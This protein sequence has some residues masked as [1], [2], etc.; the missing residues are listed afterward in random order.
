[1]ARIAS[2]LSFQMLAVAVG[3]RIY[4]L[5][6][7]AFDL[8]L[9]GLAQFIPMV[10]LTFLAG[11]VADRYDRRLVGGIC[12]VVEGIA[13]AV[14]AVGTVRGFLGRDGIYAAVAVIGA[15]RAFESPT[16]AAL[17]P[18]LLS[19][20]LV[21]R[22]S[23]WSASASQTAQI[24]GPALGGGLYILGPAIVFAV[25][26]GLFFTAAILLARIRK[27]P[28]PATRATITLRSF[29]AGLAFVWRD[30]P[31]LGT[32]SLDLFAVLFG[33]VT[34]LLPIFARDI[35]I[36]GPWGLGLLR[37][38]PAV[39]ALATSIYLGQR[40]LQTP[41]GLTMFGAV[42]MFGAA[43]IT[44]S[45]S[46]NFG[47]SLASLV[48]LGASDVVSVVIRF[49]LVQLRTPQQMRGRVSAVN[50]LFI[51]TSNQLGEF[52]SGLTAALFGTVWAALLGGIGTIAVA[53]L[54]MRLFPQLTAL[55]SLD[56]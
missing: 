1:L 49:S 54:W 41:T 12:Q 18:D 50:A 13:A 46:T 22:G 45:L 51:G 42:I 23:A 11:Q 56:G 8:G 17:L 27:A 34:A 26:A 37:A 24:I 31:I 39:G 5:T 33:G 3:W 28:V 15:A 14:L 47:L 48:V 25:A 44:F 19:R 53:V 16:L 7:S 38:A 52:E 30:P 29:F 9:V 2:S 55:R 35:L 43:T 10:L 40:P 6:N 21:E 36:T 32:V 4:A 20:G